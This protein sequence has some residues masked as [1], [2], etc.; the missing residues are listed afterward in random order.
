MCVVHKALV[1]QNFCGTSIIYE[2][3]K[4]NSKYGAGNA[5]RNAAQPHYN[6]PVWPELSVYSIREFSAQVT[7]NN[8]FWRQGCV[9]AERK[10]YC[11]TDIRNKPYMQKSYEICTSLNC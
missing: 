6:K 1:R 2:F 4:C 10:A 5:K 11:S 9:Q 3:A 7:V 8:Y